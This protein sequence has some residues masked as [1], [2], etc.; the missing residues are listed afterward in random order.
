MTIRHHPQTETLLAYAAGTLAP[1]LTALLACHVSVCRLCFEEIRCMETLGG[2]LL[3]RMQ[4]AALR[5]TAS[6]SVSNSKRRDWPV[7]AKSHDPKLKGD[8]RLPEPLARYLGQDLA[9]LDWKPTAPGIEKAEIPI[10]SCSG[11][12]YILR[13]QPGRR[14]PSHGHRGAELTMVLKGAYRDETGE[15]GKDEVADLDETIEHQP[16]V[17]GDEECICLI[18]SEHPP[19]YAKLAARPPGPSSGS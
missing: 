5:E 15:Y 2:V 4:P 12:L 8:V 18:A 10:P 16:Y 17:S 3:S 19:R 6:E 7:Q 11:D 9:D 1:A 13:V 14:L